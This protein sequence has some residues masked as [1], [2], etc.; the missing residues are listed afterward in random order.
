MSVI[1]SPMASEAT[2][3]MITSVTPT[4]DPSSKEDQVD[5]GEGKEGDRAAWERDPT[6][7]HQKPPPLHTGADWKVVLH[8]PEIEMWLRGTTE[9]V[10]EL[11]HSVHQDSLNKHVDVHL[12]QLKDICEDISDH[13]EQ[14]HALLETEFSLKLLSYSVNIIVDIR[15]VQLLWHQLRVS[16]L[17]LKERLLQGLQDS[18]GNYTRQT[19]ILQAFSQDH[20]EARLGTLTEVDDSGQLTIKCSQDYFSL[21]CGITAFEL[22]DYSPGEE[23]EGHSQG[24]EAQHRYEELEPNFPELIQ[25]VGLLT[26]AAKHLSSQ[27][28]Q[29]ATVKEDPGIIGIQTVPEP[30]SKDHPGKIPVEDSPSSSSSH[31]KTLHPESAS[32]KRPIQHCMN[33]NKVS[34]TQLSPAKK[35]MYPEDLSWDNKASLLKQAPQIPLLQFQVNMSRSTPS[36]LDL[37]DRSKFWLDLTSVYPNAVSQSYESLQVMNG[38]DEQ[39]SREVPSRSSLH[40]RSSESGQANDRLAFLPSS[41]SPQGRCTTEPKQKDNGLTINSVNSETCDDVSK[42]EPKPQSPDTSSCALASQIVP[43]QNAPLSPGASLNEEQWFGSDEYL[44]L[45]SQL[46]KT[47]ML[48]MKL[49]SLAKAL[50]Q[51][52]AEETIQDV[53]DWELSDLHSEWDSEQPL[54][55]GRRCD[56]AFPPRFSPT[57]SSE[58]APSLDESIESGPISELLSEDEAYWNAGESRRTDR[59]SWLSRSPATEGEAGPHKTL[60]QQLLEDIQHQEND[61]EIWRKIENFVNK[62]DKFICWLQEALETTENWTPPKAEADSLK[63][64]LETHLSFKLSVDSH[65]SLKD[66]VLDEGR[67][68]LQVIIS[69]KSGLRDTLQMIEHQWQELQRHVRRQHSWILCAL[70][71]IKAQ[72]MTGEAWRVAPSPKGEVQQSHCEAQ[73]DVLDQM[74]LKLNSQQYSTGSK[75]RKEFAQM[76]KV[77]TIGSNSL[78]DFES[79]YQE[80]W[81]WLLDMESI[82]MDSHELMMSEEQRQHLNK[83]NSIEMDTWAPKKSQL[84]AR[85]E[86]LRQSGAELPAD[87]EERASALVQK[88]DRL[89]RTLGELVGASNPSSPIQEPRG[90]LSPETSSMLRQLESRIKELRGWLR[91]TELFIFNSCLRHDHEHDPQAGKELQ[92]FKSLCSEVRERHRGMASVLRLCQKLLEEQERAGPDSEHQALQ[93]LTVNLERRWEAI[94]MQALQWQT[95][96]QKALGTEQ[97]PGNIIEP[98]FMDLHAPVEDSWEW[99]DMDISND[100]ISLNAKLCEL[101]K[102]QCQ[103][104]KLTLES[105]GNSSQVLDPNQSHPQRDIQSQGIN[106]DSQASHSNIYQVYSLHHIDLYNRPEDTFRNKTNVTAKHLLMKS[107]SKDSSFSSAESIPDLLGGILCKKQEQCSFCGDSARRSGSESGIM[108]EGDTETTTNSEICVLS[109]VE[110]AGGNL[111]MIPA[112]SGFS[113]NSGL[114]CDDDDANCIFDEEC[115]TAFLIGHQNSEPAKK[116][117]DESVERNRKHRRDLMEIT[118]NSVK[119]D[120]EDLDP[121]SFSAAPHDEKGTSDGKSRKGFASISQG[122]SLDSLFVAGDLFLSSK[123]TL[124]RSTSLESWLAPCKSTEDTGS[125]H[126]LGDLG[127]APE[128]MGELS[129]R[130]LELLKRLENIKTPLAQKMARSVSDITLQSSSLQLSGPRQLSLGV[131]SSMNESSAPSPTELTSA[132]DTSVGSEDLTVQKNCLGV[133]NDSF[134]KHCHGQPP[135]DETDASISMVVNVS[136]TTA[137]TDDEDDSDLLS[138]S[139]LTL[140]EEELGIKDDE[141]SSI[142][143]DEEYIEGSFAL[144]LEYMKNEIQNWI[145]PKFQSKEKSELDLGDEL[146]CG[147]FTQEK[148]PPALAV[149]DRRLLSRSP[150]KVVESNTNEKN[151]VR[152]KDTNTQKREVSRSYMRQLVDDMENGNVDN[153][154]VKGKDEDDEFLREE[155]SLFTKTGESFKDCYISSVNSGDAVMDIK[156]NLTDLPASQGIESK[157]ERQLSGEIPCC[158]SSRPSASMSSIGDCTGSQQCMQEVMHG[159]NCHEHLAFYQAHATDSPGCS[160]SSTPPEE[161]KSEDVHNFVMEIIDMASVALKNKDQ[162]VPSPTPVAQIRDKVLEHSHRPI[163]LRKGDFYAYLS[164]SSHD[165]DCGEVSTCIEDKSST[166]PPRDFRH[167]IEIKDKEPLFKACTE[168]VYLGPPLCYSMCMSQKPGKKPFSPNDCSSPR[169][170]RDQKPPPPCTEYQKA[171]GISPGSTAGSQLECHNEAAYLNPLPCETLIDTVECFADTKMLESNISPVMTKIRVSCSSTNPLKEDGSLY[172]NPKINCPQI[173]KCDRDEKGPASQQMKQKNVRKGCSSLQEA[174]STHKQSAKILAEDRRGPQIGT[175]TSSRSITCASRSRQTVQQNPATRLKSKRVATSL[176]PSVSKLQH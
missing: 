39:A 97:V 81:D 47:E 92:Y 12:V 135:P 147:T 84:L 117:R 110:D 8:L 86:S 9:R 27:H 107:L 118:P 159:N 77:N 5:L 19:N 68:L 2:S 25:S 137:C 15:S 99:D 59:P 136:C 120:A 43:D 157:L 13:V 62:L 111:P 154:Q 35:C 98:A 89:Q 113:P 56:R 142:P 52:P 87:F 167:T 65:C 102:K 17:V 78:V 23:P 71:A 90:L 54:Q 69:H 42:P 57:S 138:S 105:P 76:S 50:P 22:S 127:L 58:I 29:E 1:V 124:H 130:T 38:R 128:S 37:P 161:E 55:T 145:K 24:L 112:R 114:V 96:L 171:P 176:T 60:I 41:S 168:E 95:R 126:S 30:T 172:I 93:L 33:Y 46:K 21:D 149:N 100:L 109:Q 123:D 70:D 14:I 20:D 18:N 51:R 3:P 91:D 108:S 63:L 152:Q 151:S 72:I 155:G 160:R 153:S 73:Q 119:P 16:V 44:A 80:L 101:D 162:E 129:K 61:R 134:R 170:E 53:D 150:L 75:R 143:S 32:A 122:S 74:Y 169:N 173:R 4:L 26:V 106:L 7:C 11:T 48:A 64:Y 31:N 103:M 79:E 133:S 164:L 6:Q 40:R 131:A 156:I 67:Q 174:Q 125:Q 104:P 85:A 36:L 82:V 163:Q 10:R 144:G 140:T 141:D 146:Q 49:E 94:V 165:S 45:P 28:S 34:P 139:T 148:E 121:I 83:G 132:E 175:S 88:W 116:K 66:A 166:P 115:K 158:S